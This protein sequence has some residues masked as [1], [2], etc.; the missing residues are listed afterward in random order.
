M[1]RA[2]ES[3]QESQVLVFTKWCDNGMGVLTFVV[4]LKRII[5]HTNVSV[6]NLYPEHLR[7]MSGLLVTDIAYVS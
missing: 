4:K 5:L 1:W 3:H 7:K 2:F 6:K